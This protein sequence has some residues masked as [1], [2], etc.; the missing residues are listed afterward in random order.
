MVKVTGGRRDGVKTRMRWNDERMRKEWK[1]GEQ[2]RWGGGGSWWKG[3]KGNRRKEKGR[4]KRSRKWS[5]GSR[6]EIRRGRRKTIGSGK[7]RSSRRDSELVGN[8]RV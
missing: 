4:E 5:K 1:N 3:E 2:R 7:R 6:I 8:Y